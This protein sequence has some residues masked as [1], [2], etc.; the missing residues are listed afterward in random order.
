VEYFKLFIWLYVP[1]APVNGFD[2]PSWCLFV[3][4]RYF[5]YLHVAS[6]A[7]KYKDKKVMLFCTVNNTNVSVHVPVTNSQ[8]KLL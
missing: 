5:K 8:S 3:A 4:L 2:D 6:I 7:T 1:F